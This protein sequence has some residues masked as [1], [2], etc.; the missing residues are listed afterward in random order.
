[1]GLV[2]R[3]RRL[4]QE[5]LQVKLA[6]SLHAATDAERSAIMPVN[7]RW[8]LE[9]LMAACNDYVEHT[10]RRI[11]FEWALI[12][13]QNDTP[14]VAHKLGALL[15]TLNKSCHV[16]LIPLNPTAGFDGKPTQ[17]AD[18]R[19]FV[20]ILAE[21]GVAA[22]PR[23]RR[24]IDIDAGAGSSRPRSARSQAA[25]APRSDRHFSGASGRMMTEERS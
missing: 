21:Y 12:A 13:G 22:T 4:A 9:E 16:N 25:V 19:V 14:D 10:G 3:I 24:G 20:E 8:P 5:G 2:P 18:C 15:A 23:V 1:M 11:T 6:V 17:A 7:V